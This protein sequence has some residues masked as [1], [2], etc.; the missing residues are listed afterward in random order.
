MPDVLPEQY[1]FV[2]DYLLFLHDSLAQALV[3]GEKA[4]VFDTEVP[5][6]EGDAQVF[7]NIED[8]NILEWLEANGRQE[9][10]ATI[11]YKMTI[12]AL[13]S[14]FCHYVFEGL[15]CSRKGKLAPAFSLFR[16]PFCDTLAYLE[17]MLADPEGFMGTFLHDSP[18]GLAF[19]T[20]AE[21]QEII[22]KAII[23]T[24]NQGC[25]DAQ[26][27]YELRYDKK[28]PHGLQ[29]FFQQSTHL[30]TTMSKHIKSQP[31]NFNMVF[32]GDEDRQAQWSFIYTRLP[33]LLVYAVEVVEALLELFA[34]TEPGFLE[35]MSLRRTAGFVLCADRLGPSDG[36]PP[37]L[38][39][40]VDTL[41]KELASCPHC[42][43]GQEISVGSV[44]ELYE[45]GAIS[46]SACKEDM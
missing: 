27:I 23:R 2:H 16:K 17:W 24:A 13:L 26:A 9:Y 41:Q 30:I 18:D 40:F 22:D 6:E 33:Y 31:Q 10:A 35:K 7:E 46:C 8:E 20:T 15:S 12:R 38:V 29:A 32:S 28:A 5:L 43:E 36:D 14:D 19:S 3:E 39:N 11:M 44:E 42:G 34:P 1:R 37:T 21:K 25:F 45:S 4:H